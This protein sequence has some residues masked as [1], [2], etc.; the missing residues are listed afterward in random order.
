MDISL[1]SYVSPENSHLDENQGSVQ[2]LEKYNLDC[3]QKTAGP[4]LITDL[5][6]EVS[7]S[8][9]EICSALL[10]SEFNHLRT[11]MLQ[12]FQAIKAL[13]PRRESARRKHP[14]AR[15]SDIIETLHMRLSLL[16]M[17]FG[18]H[19]ERNYC[20][21]FPGEIIDE[22]YRILRY[23]KDNP[24]LNRA[25]KVT[26]EL[27]DL[28]TMAMEYFKEH[29]EPS[30]PEIP[31]L[32]HDLFEHSFIHPKSELS[33]QGA[34]LLLEST[35]I[36]KETDQPKNDDSVMKFQK[37]LKSTRDMAKRN[38]RD[39]IKIKQ[40]LKCAKKRVSTVIKELQEIKWQHKNCKKGLFPEY[41]SLNDILF[42]IKRQKQ[43]LL[44]LACL[45]NCANNKSSVPEL[46]PEKSYSNSDQSS[47]EG[48]PSGIDKTSCFSLNKFAT[49]VTCFLDDGKN[50]IT[51]CSLKV[52][53]KSQL[54]ISNENSN[55][56][57]D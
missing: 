7:K 13:M 56:T 40:S 34:Q 5:P 50:E 2:T 45:S 6:S 54:H 25:Y 20:C 36:R 15:E 37:Q 16:H 24:C 28:S 31:F 35:N 46:L 14:L 30:L 18:K 4:P 27:F 23:M 32:A 44:K 41:C 17:T 11:I 43:E 26:D 51:D 3:Q 47:Y 52:P 57:K 39:I 8:F 42:D 29:I 9:N 55:T 33:F 21:F 12:K 53:E 19:I 49:T 22:I 10:N 1:N 38:R 48:I